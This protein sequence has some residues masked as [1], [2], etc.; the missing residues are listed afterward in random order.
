MILIQSDKKEHSSYEVQQ[1]LI[2]ENFKFIIFNKNEFNQLRE[3]NT[4]LN[5]QKVL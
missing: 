3:L 1:W 4:L 5:A 2:F